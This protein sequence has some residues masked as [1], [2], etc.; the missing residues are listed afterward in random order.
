[1]SWNELRNGRR[2]IEQGEYFITFVCDN[3]VKHFKNDLA[4][5]IFCQQIAFNERLHSS[6]WLAWV[7][8][9][10]HFHGLLRLGSSS[11]GKTVGHFKG[12]SA[13]R[14]NDSRYGRAFTWQSAYFDRALRVEEDRV[15]VARYIVAN[16]LR[17][18]LVK[19]IGDYPYWDSKYL[20][21]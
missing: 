11:L 17:G 21:G 19:S 1:M 8:M 10:D 20:G 2:S 9:P 14:I 5:R 13:K 15:A 16:P 18:N 6:C 7:L 3:R 12:L 4:A